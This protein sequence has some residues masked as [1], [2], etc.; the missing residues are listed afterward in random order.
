[1]LLIQFFT[2]DGKS[3]STLVDDLMD[4]DGIPL[5]IN[6][7][8]AGYVVISKQTTI[9]KICIFPDEDSEPNLYIYE[10]LKKIKL[11]YNSD[12]V[13]VFPPNF[14]EEINRGTN[15]TPF[16]YGIYKFASKYS[17]FIV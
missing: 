6:N 8:R 9:F 16:M 7:E 17:A 15:L 10:L 5:I 2:K 12:Q 14:N 13:A 11:L 1:M 4:E 3:L